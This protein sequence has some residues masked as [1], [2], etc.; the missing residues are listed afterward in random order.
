MSV[1]KFGHIYHTN[2]SI[3]K[4]LSDIDNLQTKVSDLEKTI[5]RLVILIDSKTAEND[6]RWQNLYITNKNLVKYEPR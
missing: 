3:E 6:F 2:K 4:I 5:S 1:D